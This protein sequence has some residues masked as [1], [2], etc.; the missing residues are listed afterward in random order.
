[1]EAL[2][3]DAVVRVEVPFSAVVHEVPLKA[4]EQW[5][6]APS[7]SPQ[8]E[9]LKGPCRRSSAVRSSQ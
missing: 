7:A 9:V 2:G 4:L 3:P 5:A 6:N 1:M 8:E